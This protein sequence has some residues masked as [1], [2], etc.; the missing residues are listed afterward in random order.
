[1]MRALVRTER[2][3]SPKNKVAAP[4]YVQWRINMRLMDDIVVGF[5][6]HE[7]PTIPNKALARSRQHNDTAKEEQSLVSPR[8]RKHWLGNISNIID[9]TERNDG[10]TTCHV[11]YPRGILMK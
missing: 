10:T 4:Q 5:V 7:I 9:T 1:M 8:A 11:S 2:L 6:P 3:A